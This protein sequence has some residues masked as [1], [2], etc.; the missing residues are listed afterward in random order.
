MVYLQFYFAM[1]LIYAT[2][3]AVWGWLC[4]QHVHELLPIQVRRLPQF[5]VSVVLY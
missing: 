2:F 4:Y 5:D 1:S 3:A